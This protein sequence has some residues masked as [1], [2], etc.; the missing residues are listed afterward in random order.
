MVNATDNILQQ[1]HM[2]ELIGFMEVA[3]H[4]HTVLTVMKPVKDVAALLS[5]CKIP[6][7][8]TI[9]SGLP[10]EVKEW[11][12]EVAQLREFV[13]S[14]SDILEPELQQMCSEKLN[15]IQSDIDSMA[16]V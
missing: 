4:L 15:M 3:D 8:H 9:S 13:G 16:Q 1:R 2:E 5:K 11:Q 6:K 7:R 10:K 12:E 14:S